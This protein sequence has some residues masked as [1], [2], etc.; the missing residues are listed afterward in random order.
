MMSRGTKKINLKH[1]KSSLLVAVAVEAMVMTSASAQITSPSAPLR[2]KNNLFGYASSFSPRVTFTD[3]IDLQEEPLD[4][5]DLILT[6]FFSGSAIFSNR[7]FTGLLNGDIDLS[8]L[9]VDGDFRINQDIGGTGTATIAENWVY[10]DVSGQTSRQLIGDNASFSSNRNA[11][12]DQQA[13]VHSFSLSPYVYHQFPNQSAV[14]LRYRFSQVFIDGNDSGAGPGADEFL[15]DSQ[16]NEALISFQT[17]ALFDRLRLVVSAYGNNTVEDGSI[18]VPR[19][20]YQQGSI[21]AEGQFAL[22][23][24]FSLSGAI[25]FDEVSTESVVP[26]FDDD[27]LSGLFWRA[28]FTARPGR[29]TQLRLEYGQR[30]DDD[31]IDASLNYRVSQRFT[32]T[33][34]AARTFQTRAQ[35]ITRRFRSLQLSTLQFADQ[36]R[37]GAE[38]SPEALINSVNAIGGGRLDAQAVGIGASNTAF[39]R[40]NGVFDRTNVSL[41]AEYSDTDFGFRQNQSFGGTFNITRELSRKTE[42]YGNLFYRH[43][44]T[45]IDTTN[46]IQAPFL[47]GLDTSVP[48]F[49]PVVSCNEFAATNG[50]TDTVGGSVGF[51]HQFYKNLA[52]FGEYSHTQRFSEIT[53]LEYTE[54]SVTAGLTLDF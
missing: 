3:N 7:R 9:T 18:V 15:N 21:L 10:L 41:R 39:A 33:A 25:G 42:A 26:L 1:I 32:L 20:E 48:G 53:T 37:Q 47:F 24:S 19:F 6:S 45:S 22:N 46:C 28:G 30:Y 8:Y 11:G 43:A 29:R 16:T 49:D 54:N 12:R 5:N 36:I 17:G 31:F 51:S 14:E 4:D 35:S 27:T 2:F 23:R 44:D 52:F 40:V 38:L 34:G 13:N 50:V